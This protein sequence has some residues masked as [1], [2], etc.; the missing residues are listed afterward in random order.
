MSVITLADRTSYEGR[1]YTSFGYE[2]DPG[3]TGR[4]TWAMNKTETWQ[5]NAGAI[6]PNAAAEISQRLIS[7]EPM[8]S[9]RTSLDL[10][11]SKLMYC[12]L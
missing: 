3:P 4:I 2:Y 12:L 9:C 1:G 5:L 6:G 7:E 10:D 8:V 11:E